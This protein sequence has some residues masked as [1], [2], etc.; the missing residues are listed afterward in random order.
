MTL[1]VNDGN[2]H[3]F[4]AIDKES[5]AAYHA[6]QGGSEGD[7]VNY[8]RVDE[9]LNVTV[10]SVVERRPDGSLKYDKRPLDILPVWS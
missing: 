3:R 8:V 6:I 7:E 1:Y 5:G 9:S 2:F 10:H 4:V